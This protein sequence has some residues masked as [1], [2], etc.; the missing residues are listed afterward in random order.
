MRFTHKAVFI[1]AIF[2]IASVVYSQGRDTLYFC[3]QYS[4]GEEIGLSNTFAIPPGGDSITVMV[5]TNGPVNE[6]HVSIAVDKSQSGAFTRIGTHKFD[7][8]PGWD[9]I[10]FDG[11]NFWSEGFYTVRLLREDG[12]EIANNTVTMVLLN[13]KPK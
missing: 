9:Y 12:T 6:K 3:R 13:E 4:K 10:F 7:I 5:K 11:I 2:L 8:E 1:A